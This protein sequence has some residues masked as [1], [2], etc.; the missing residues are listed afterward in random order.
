MGLGSPGLRES[1][2]GDPTTDRI[3]IGITHLQAGQ[4][5]QTFP[6]KRIFF[7]PLFSLLAESVIFR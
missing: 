4:E 1:A 7:F 2:P 3:T 5:A 6:V